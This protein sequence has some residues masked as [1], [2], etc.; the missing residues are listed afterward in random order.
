VH[1]ANDSKL[2]NHGS[3]ATRLAARPEGALEARPDKAR[4]PMATGQPLLTRYKGPLWAF[5]IAKRSTMRKARIP[6]A[7]SSRHHHARQLLARRSDSS[8]TACYQAMSGLGQI[9]PKTQVGTGAT[10]GSIVGSS[11]AHPYGRFC[12]D[13]RPS[14]GSISRSRQRD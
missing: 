8:S 3:L 12:A 2:V 7:H 6:L 13:T 4:L 11:G 14:A 1:R 9:E 10:Q 5:A